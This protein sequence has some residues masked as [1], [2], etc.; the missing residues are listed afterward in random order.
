MNNIFTIYL[1]PARSGELG[2]GAS[3]GGGIGGNSRTSGGIG[4]NS[5]SSAERMALAQAQALAEAANAARGSSQNS[6]QKRLVVLSGPAIF[7]QNF[8]NAENADDDI[9]KSLE[10]NGFDVAN[11]RVIKQSLIWNN[12]II[13]LELNVFDNIT[14]EEVRQRAQQI[15]SQMTTYLIV[16]FAN[17]KVFQNVQLRIVSDFQTTITDNSTNGAN[18]NGGNNNG[19]SALDDFLQTLAGTLGISTAVAGA[20]LIVFAAIILKK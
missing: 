5:R 12:V 4:G 8:G 10:D 9:R 17:Y 19:K 13:E 20:G 11:V 16:S 2:D 7:N 14:A 6:G 1:M 15:I 3:A 18:N